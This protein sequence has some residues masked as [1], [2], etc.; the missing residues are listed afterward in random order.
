LRNPD[1]AIKDSES[2]FL[3]RRAATALASAAGCPF[4]APLSSAAGSYPHLLPRTQKKPPPT[5]LKA[6]GNGFFIL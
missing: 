2:E 6:D 3:T 5:A 4:P 1:S